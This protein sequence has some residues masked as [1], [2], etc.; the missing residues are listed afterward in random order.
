ML[1]HQPSSCFSVLLSPPKQLPSFASRALL[2]E[3]LMGSS[4]IPGYSIHV[5]FSRSPWH[6][7]P[8]PGS[9]P[10][11][12]GQ[13]PG[14]APLAGDTVGTHSA[15]V[16]PQPSARG[17]WR[18]CCW[19]ET[20][21]QPQQALHGA[22]RALTPPKAVPEPHRAFSSLN[23]V[24]ALAQGQGTSAMAMEKPHHQS[25]S[26]FWESPDAVRE[27]QRG[28]GPRTQRGLPHSPFSA[29]IRWIFQFIQIKAAKSECVFPGFNHLAHGMIAWPLVTRAKPWEP[30][31]MERSLMFPPLP[32]TS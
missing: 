24:G 8:P 1:Q 27:L 10:Q 3:H 5:P 13:C 30:E 22:H 9:C 4:Q 20:I 29:A 26:T 31:D 32:G 19:A 12:K 18:C 16:P 11:L 6:R 17:V 15:A 25:N 23:Y 2:L 7:Q 28:W 14:P 21:L